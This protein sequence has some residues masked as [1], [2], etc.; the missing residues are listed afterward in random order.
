MIQKRSRRDAIKMSLT[1]LVGV[2]AITALNACTQCSKPADTT[3]APASAPNPEA[4]AP[5]PE[6]TAPSSDAAAT[7]VAPTA[8]G[9][10]T[11]TLVSDSDP[12]VTSLNY[13]HNAADVPAE[14][15]TEKSGVPFSQQNC[16]SCMFYKVAGQ[17][18]GAEVGSCQ[19]FANGK[20]KSTGWC[21]SWAKKA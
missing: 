14:Q 15:Q 7:N 3:S 16:S 5:S 9:G 6:A 8:T 18:D 17:L 1:A 2:P 19:L 20:V 21:V 11:L 12:T 13:K 10:E 4:A